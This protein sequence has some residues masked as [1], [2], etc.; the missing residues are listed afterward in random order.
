[1][2]SGMIKMGRQ[3]AKNILPEV[4]YVLQRVKPNHTQNP[5]K[6]LPIHRRALAKNILPEVEYVQ[7]VKPNHTQNPTKNLPIHRRRRGCD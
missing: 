2:P 5:T 4:E 3:P 7:R 6:N 1:M